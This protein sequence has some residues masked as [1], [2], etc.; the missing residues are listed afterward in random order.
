M[1]PLNLPNPTHTKR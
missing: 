1:S